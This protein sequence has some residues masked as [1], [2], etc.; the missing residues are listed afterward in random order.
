MVDLGVRTTTATSYCT[1]ILVLT[2][3]SRVRSRDWFIFAVIRIGSTRRGHREF[4]MYKRIILLALAS[5]TCTFHDSQASDPDR[6]WHHWRGPLKRGEA[7]FAN[8][9][10]TWNEQ[11]NVRWKIRIPGDGSSTPIISGDRVFITTAI[12]TDRKAE[13]APKKD[14]RSKT[15]PP[16]FYYQFVVLCVD[17]S[18]GSLLWQTTVRESV[19]VEGIHGTNSYASGSPVTD[20]SRLYVSFGSHGIYC[21]TFE[22]KIVWERDLGDMRTRYGWGE[23]STPAVHKDNV[24][25]IWDHEDQ[26]FAAVLDAKSGATRWKS[27]RDEPTSWATPIVVRHDGRDQLIVNGTNRV[28]SYDLS[29]GEVIWQCGGQTVNAIPTPIEWNGTVVCMS[30]YRGYA[31][32]SI[33]LSATGDITG[34]NTIRWKHDRGTPYVPSPLMYDGKVYFTRKNSPIL[35]CVDATS[36]ELVFEGKRLGDLKTL[37]AS[38][39]AANGRIYVVDRDGTTMVLRAGPELEVLATNKLDDQVDGSPAMVGEQLFLRGRKYL[40]C[41]ESE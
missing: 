1:A 6:Q 40:Y 20:G 14:E 5:A 21:L 17:R 23:A 3:L 25:I 4:N 7:L 19:P 24:I 12:R 10:T 37:Y 39:V 18:S 31:A 2:I 9:P 29:T 22:G 32:Y 38:P 28:R 35:S 27:D 41:L 8:P 11:S 30:G 34:S 15:K 26:S 36:G 33:P 16:P 13:V